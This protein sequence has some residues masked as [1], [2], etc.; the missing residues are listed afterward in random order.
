MIVIIIAV[1]YDAREDVLRIIRHA[2]WRLFEWSIGLVGGK[3][4]ERFQQPFALVNLA[5]PERVLGQ[6]MTE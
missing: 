4:L 6:K 1:C 2:L 5:V 3:P